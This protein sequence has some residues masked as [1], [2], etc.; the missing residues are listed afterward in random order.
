[1]DI[2]GKLTDFVGGGLFKEIKEAV[3]AY[4]PPDITPEQKVQFELQM[5]ETLNQKQRDGEKVLADAAA[6]LDKRIAEQEG[7]ASDLKGV[8]IL[9]T[10]VIFFRGC[11]RPAWGF[12]TMGMD[13]MWFFQTHTFTDKQDL[14]MIIINVLVL[15]FLFGE[16]T[17]LNLQPLIERVFAAKS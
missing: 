1:M 2:L 9:G 7:T 3:M 14:A 13:W 8:P 5:Q 15:G 12:A 11:Q 4:L 16:R 6:Q 10:M 17:I